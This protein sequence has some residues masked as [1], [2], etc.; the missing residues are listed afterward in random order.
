MEPFLPNHVF[1]PRFRLVLSLTPKAANTSI[2]Q[3]ML[4]AM[5]RRVRLRTNGYRAYHRSWLRLD[6]S[7]ASPDYLVIG[8]VRNPE[9]RLKSCFKNKIRD[10]GTTEPLRQQYGWPESLD[11][12]EFVDRVCEIPDENADVHFRGQVYSMSV[13]G[14]LRPDHI[15]RFEDLTAGPGW[16][17]FRELVENQTG[18]QLRKDLPHRNATDSRPLSVD[19]KTRAKIR[20]RYAEDYQ[21]FYGAENWKGSPIK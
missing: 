8:V 16:T 14:E 21:I 20:E 2:K 6:L 19:P 7:E 17:R 10:R 5:K 13:D 3:A 11:F 15:I 4:E 1:L 12:S 9:D 18:L